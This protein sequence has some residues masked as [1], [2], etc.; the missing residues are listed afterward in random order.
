M[1]KQKSQRTKRKAKEA[2]INFN[3]SKKS[4]EKGKLNDG[5]DEIEFL[6]SN[7]RKAKIIEKDAKPEL[8][9]TDRKR[10][11]KNPTPSSTRQWTDDGL[12]GKFNGEGYTGRTQDGCRIFKA[13]VLNMPRSGNTKDC[14]FDCDCC[15]I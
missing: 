12:G 14:P 1:A 13:H 10:V 2:S 15:F 3:A 11:K 6:F 7:K 8:R 4:D 9:Q 5:L